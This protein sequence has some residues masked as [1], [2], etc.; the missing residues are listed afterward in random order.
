MHADFIVM[1]GYGHSRLRDF[2]L[3]VKLVD[4]SGLT[5]RDKA[6]DGLFIPE[7]PLPRDPAARVESGALESANVTATEARADENLWHLTLAC[8]GDLDRA[9]ELG[10]LRG[11]EPDR[12]RRGTAGPATPR[13]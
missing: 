3:G 1:G 9:V 4:G 13:R 10:G 7:A 8:E 12:A 11:V 6:G 5:P 2:V